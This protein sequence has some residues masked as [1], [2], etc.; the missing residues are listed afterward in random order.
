MKDHK[1]A[2]STPVADAGI[3]GTEF[4]AGPLEKY[5]VLLLEG[6][7]R[8]SNQAGSVVLAKSGQGTD[9]ASARSIRR[10]SRRHGLRRR[11]LAPSPPSPCTDRWE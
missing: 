9:I 7:V 1:I 5:G 2:V 8:V 3:R 10:E 6:E 11:S 4:W